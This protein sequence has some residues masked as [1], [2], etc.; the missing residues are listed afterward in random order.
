MHATTFLSVVAFAAACSSD[1]GQ[2][3]LDGGASNNV[4]ITAT[5][6]TTRMGF[7]SDGIGYWQKDDSIA[8]WSSSDNK[9]E[10]FVIARGAG[11][12]TATFRGKV[13]G[14]ITSETVILYPYNANHTQTT[15]YLPDT[16][17]YKSV[18]KE[19][20]VKDGGNFQMPMKG[21]ISGDGGKYTATFTHLGSLLAI[22]VVQMPS[23]TGTV[24]VT[25]TDNNLCGN[26][27]ITSSIGMPDGGKAVTFK[28][29]GAEVDS[30]GVFYLPVAPASYTIKVNVK[31]AD[32][33]TKSYVYTTVEMKQGHIKPLTVDEGYTINGHK[34][35]DLG[36]PSGLLWA[37]T[38]IGAVDDADEGDY[39]AWGETEPRTSF[40]ENAYKWY[41]DDSVTKYDDDKN[42][43]EDAD[44]AAIAKWGLPCC[45]P[46]ADEIDELS[47]KDYCDWTYIKRTRTDGSEIKGFSVRSRKNDNSIFLP[48]SGYYD[49]TH[50][51]IGVGRFWA[52]T[53]G[54]SVNLYGEFT[55]D[56]MTLESVLTGGVFFSLRSNGMNIR[57]VAMP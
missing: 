23:A 18:D 13:K 1:D 45:M 7:D 38:N 6:P 12:G 53:R 28:Y 39:Y 22:K 14:D 32:G 51:Q 20:S 30:A 3:T 21:T 57:P 40:P 34:F 27:S 31:N 33:E 4:T 50:H 24:T 37:E 9:F 11:E 25:S 16:Y 41:N 56:C 43:L 36:L 54:Y 44:D 5:Q 46:T 10:P 29:S 17:I 55:A 2:E 47:N 15:Y 42:T 19:Y 35:I 26:A 49:N 8:V 48:M 52:K